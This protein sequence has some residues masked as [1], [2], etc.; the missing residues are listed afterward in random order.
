MTNPAPLP[1]AGPVRWCGDSDRADL[2]GL[3]T[4]LAL[5]DL[6]FNALVFL[7]AAISAGLDCG[8]VHEHISATTIDGDEAE[9]LLGVEPFNGSLRHLSLL[10]EGVP[11]ARVRAFVLAVFEQ[12]R[13]LP[14]TS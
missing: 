11:A 1:V 13:L 4:L 6:E 14:I 2:L 7:E 9:A 5:G 12:R 3:W 10:H 8:E